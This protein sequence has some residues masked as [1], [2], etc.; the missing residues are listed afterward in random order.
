MGYTTQRAEQLVAL[1]P[2]GISE[3]PDI[4]AQSVRTPQEWS[5]MLAARKLPVLRGWRLSSDDLLRSGSSSV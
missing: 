2:S 4:Y 3:L 1:G 5:R